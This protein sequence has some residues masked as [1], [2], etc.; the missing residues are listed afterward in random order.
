[1][2]S[3]LQFCRKFVTERPFLT[4]LGLLFFF[5]FCLIFFRIFYA[6]EAYFLF[7]VWNL[8]LAFLPFVMIQGAY[9]LKTRGAKPFVV[10]AVGGMSL[11]FL[12]NSPYII[13]DL[14]HLKHWHHSAPLWFDTLLI[15]SYA[16]TG[17]ILFYATI[18]IM[19]KLLR[20]YFKSN[21]ANFFLIGI[22]F[23][24]A[25]GIYLGRYMRFNSWDIIS[26]P[27]SLATEILSYIAD[28]LGHPRIWG[29]TFTYGM[30]FFVGY[31]CIKLFQQTIQ[32]EQSKSL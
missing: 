14:F 27:M 21:T 32:N 30:L 29:V 4:A 9:F 13:T 2:Q 19:E 25:F 3:L 16:S 5:N 26:N 18:L 8:F 12:P 28:P 10:L 23:L 1:M 24:T 11:L 22:L 17:I 7:L 6:Q 31:C 15:F 20:A